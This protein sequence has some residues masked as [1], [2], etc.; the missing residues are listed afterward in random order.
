ML[1]TFV[2]ES[3]EISKLERMIVSV[4]SSSPVEPPLKRAKIDWEIVDEDGSTSEGDAV[5]I[6]ALNIGESNIVNPLRAC[7]F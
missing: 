3:K 6:V 1:L 2:G 5:W 7:R 4:P